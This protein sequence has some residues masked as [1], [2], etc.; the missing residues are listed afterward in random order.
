[1]DGV[2]D[3]AGLYRMDLLES[4]LVP[5]VDELNR[6]RALDR[7]QPLLSLYPGQAGQYMNDDKGNGTTS[8]FA[9]IDTATGEV[10]GE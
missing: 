10:I 1:M 2:S 7:T 8:Q 5:R 3:I 4:V 9:A 6:V